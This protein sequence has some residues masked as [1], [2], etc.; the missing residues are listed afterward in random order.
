MANYTDEQ[1]QKALEC[2]KTLNCKKCEKRTRFKTAVYCRDELIGLALDLINRQEAEKQKLEYILSGVMLFVD[3]WLEGDELSQDEVNRA[4]IM[5]ER[6][7]EIVEKQEAEIERLKAKQKPTGA[8]G[9]KIENGKVVFFTTTL[10]G[11]RREYESLDEVVKTLNE[12]LHEAYSKDEIL[13]YYRCAIKDLKTAKAEA[14]KGY[15]NKI[16]SL[17]PEDQCCATIAKSTLNIFEK[18]M[19]G[20]GE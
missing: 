13:F 4:R 2:C 1:I 16:L 3:K 10:G 18:E 7:L 14:I 12:L 9:Y 17:F 20:E 5:R 15:K 11:Y 19:V 6:T 8:S